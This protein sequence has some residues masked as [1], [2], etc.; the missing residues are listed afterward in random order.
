MK[1]R[2]GNIRYRG[3]H[4]KYPYGHPSRKI[5]EEVLEPVLLLKGA[6]V[7]SD[8]GVKV[9]EGMED[10]HRSLLAFYKGSLSTYE[11]LLAALEPGEAHG[12]ENASHGEEE[13]AENGE[14]ADEIPEEETSHEEEVSSGGH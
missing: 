4:E 3:V 10:F 6:G 9:P 11:G 7:D 5:H 12:E 8:K 2:A 14:N 1:R 13:T